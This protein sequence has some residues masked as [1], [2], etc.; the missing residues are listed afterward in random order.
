MIQ[1][2]KIV[3]TMRKISIFAALV[4][5]MTAVSCVK[6]MNVEV[7]ENPSGEQINESVTFKATFGAATKAV[8]KPG[9][10]ESKVEWEA[11]DQVSVLAGEGNYLYK[12]SEAGVTTDLVTEEKAVPAEGAYYAVYPYDENAVLSEGVISTVLP[13]E[14]TAVLGSFTTHLSVS[15]AVENNFTFR[16]VCG[17]VKVTVDAENVTKIVFEGNSGE[18]VAGGIDVTVADAPTWVAR[19][20]EGQKSISLVAGEGSLAKGA[21]YF[22]VLPQT[23]AAGFKVTAYKGEESWVIRNV[24]TSTTIERSDI[25]GSKAFFEIDGNGTEE[26]PYLLKTPEHL[27]GMRTLATYGG[28]TWFKMMNDINM[29]GVTNFVPVNI[30]NYFDRKI[31]F[32]G[33][34]FTISNLKPSG[35]TY[36]SLFGV[37]YGTCKDLKIHNATISSSATCGVLAGYVGTFQDNTDRTAYVENVHITN[38]SVRCTGQQVGGVCGVA[39]GATFKNV[40]Y[41]GTVDCTYV[42]EGKTAAA[43]LEARLGGFVG[44]VKTHAKSSLTT[45]L[46][47]DD[48]HVDATVTDKNGAT[49]VGGFIGKADASIKVQNSTVK[50][51]VKGANYCA[52]FLATAYGNVEL[53]D[54]Q[55]EASVEASSSVAAFM[56]WFSKNATGVLT[57]CKATGSV[58]GKSNVGGLLGIVENTSENTYTMTDCEYTG[59]SINAT[60]GV[61]GGL[62]GQLAG[63][64]TITGSTVKTDITAGGNYAGGLVGSCTANNDGGTVTANISNCHYEGTLNVTGNYAGGAVGVVQTKCSAFTMSNVT[65]KGSVTGVQYVGGAIGATM[66]AKDQNVSNCSSS[67]AVKSTGIKTGGFVGAVTSTCSFT[68][69]Y[70]TGAVESSARSLGGFIGHNNG[71]NTTLTNCY[72]TGNVKSTTDG[73]VGGFL[74]NTETNKTILT[75]CHATGNVTCASGNNVGGLVGV[76]QANIDIN[77]CYSTGDVEGGAAGRCA[78]ILGQILIGKATIKNSYSTGN[79]TATG[80]QHGGIVGYVAE[81]NTK[82][83]IACGQVAIENCF[84]SGTIGTGNGSAGILGNSRADANATS[85]IGCIAWNEKVTSNVRGSGNYAPAAVVGSCYK[86]GI[87]KNCWRRADMTLVDK[88][89]LSKLVDQDDCVG[90]LPYLTGAPSNAYNPNRAYQGKAAAADATISSVAK[91]IGWDETVWDLSGDTPKLK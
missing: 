18:V 44:F 57:R 4:V 48:C 26:N 50:G 45:L 40:T 15:Q 28:E 49:M 32:D 14:Q 12:A 55:S 46:D 58:T 37:L 84:A 60:A 2:S 62:V 47:C 21:Y 76:A 67:A 17:L 66:G 86:A 83:N 79:V 53:T 41:Q 75:G 72:A 43:D 59:A 1:F 88:A 80:M 9:E 85:V 87:F 3:M 74:G 91:A 38:S 42:I 29:E 56:G 54:C 11:D 20:G 73:Y 51:S 89:N 90:E 5:A 61:V 10:T 69:C 8:L 78:G 6:E 34:N 39:Q 71:A 19:E 77:E 16:N 23:F 25:V 31:H 35:K 63:Q 68:D 33:G 13:A 70:A 22:A 7:P 82:N 30:D 64:W 24:V 36:T 52:G 65:T 27:V 81:A